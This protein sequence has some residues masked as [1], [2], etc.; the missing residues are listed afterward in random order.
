[1]NTDNRVTLRAIEPEDLDLLY[2][3]END[4]ELWDV[5]VTNVPYSRYVLHS[6]SSNT[7]S[8]IY[9]DKQVRLVIENE[10]HQ[11]IGLADLM[12]FDPKNSRAELGLVVL[13]EFRNKGY[14]R[15]AVLRLQEYALNT[16][17]L[18]QIY[19]VIPVENEASLQI[20]RKLNYHITAH[21]SD[22]LFDGVRYHDAV[23]VQHIL[24]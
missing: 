1:M 2:R 20:F 24:A 13:R 9:V 10:A 6:F 11:V 12:S 5:G 17:H 3:I 14:A 15:E 23:V 16:L 22:W 18:H 21:L 8:D 7:T 4:K 19:A